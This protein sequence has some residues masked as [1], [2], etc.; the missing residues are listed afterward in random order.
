MF[1]RGVELLRHPLP[2]PAP[3]RGVL[4]ERVRHLAEGQLLLADERV[5]E[6]QR[7]DLVALEVR[8][9]WAVVGDPDRDVELLLVGLRLLRRV[10]TAFDQVEQRREHRVGGIAALAGEPV[11]E[12][13]PGIV[14]RLGQV[15]RDVTAAVFAREQAEQGEEER[16]QPGESE[17]RED[18]VVRD[19]ALELLVRSVEVLVESLL[20][21]DDLG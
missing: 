1:L 19:P 2:A 8:R 16:R 9:G 10:V 13:G 5:E 18:R 4:R 15:L 3:E 6:L 14:G 21:G 11:G 20:E 7:L 12:R 17:R